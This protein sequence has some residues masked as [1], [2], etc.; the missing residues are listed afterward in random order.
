MKLTGM[1]VGR[2]GNVHA[3]VP[4][5]IRTDEDTL[6]DF[7]NGSINTQKGFFLA[8]RPTREATGSSWKKQERGAAMF[9]YS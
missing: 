6:S 8:K 7:S 4:G 5:D 1:N 2:K 3:V 9:P